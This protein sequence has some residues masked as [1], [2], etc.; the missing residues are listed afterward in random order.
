MSLNAK[1]LPANLYEL[2]NGENLA[3][4]QHEAM[5]LL[6]MDESMWPHTAMIS[7]GE[8]IAITPERLKLSLW[9]NTTTTNNIIRTGKAAFVVF[10]DGAAHYVK[11][12]LEKL[13]EL[14]GAKYHR[15]RFAAD[16]VSYKGDMAKYA[17][18]TSGIQIELKDPDTVI[19]RWEETIA[20]L[21]Y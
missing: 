5:M 19:K 3:D 17:A 14:K 7:V 9:P 6:T 18:I 21:K 12:S 2:L 1:Q 13:P 8:I 16:I 10:F 15:E 4:K 20:E 11:L